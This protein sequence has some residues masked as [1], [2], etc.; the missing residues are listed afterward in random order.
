MNF[1]VEAN[2]IASTAV[3]GAMTDPVT[4]ISAPP[5]SNFARLP[6]SAVV[7]V[8]STPTEGSVNDLLMNPICCSSGLLTISPTLA[9][10]WQLALRVMLSHPLKTMDVSSAFF[11]PI[12]LPS[13]VVDVH[14]IFDLFTASSVAVVPLPLNPGFAPGP[15]SQL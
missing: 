6:A 2:D 5:H 8:R 3:I 12:H 13:S 15:G 11:G 14:L 1:V 10:D 4:K 9:P 7:G